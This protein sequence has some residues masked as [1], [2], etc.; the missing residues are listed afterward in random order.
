[1]RR[2]LFEISFLIFLMLPALA[3]L[4][5]PGFYQSQD[6]PSHLLRL[7]HFSQTF[8]DGQ[9]P[10]R[11]I[12][13]LAYGLGTPLFLFNFPLPYYIG[14]LLLFLGFS[15]V[16]SIEILFGA[17]MLLSG[18]FFYLW[19]RQRY[20][21][22]AAFTGALFYMWAPYRF[23]VMYHRAALGEAMA[24][25]FIPLLF[26]FIDNILEK[27]RRKPIIGL[28]VSYGLLITTHNVAALM[29]TGILLLYLLFQYSKTRAVRPLF[30]T[31]IGLF[32]GIGLAGFFWIPAVVEVGWTRLPGLA[33]TTFPQHF[34]PPFAL[35]RSAWEG[36]SI[37]NGKTLGMSFQLGLIHIL[38]FIGSAALVFVKRTSRSLLYPLF[39]IGLTILSVFLML[40]PSE[41]LYK[42]IPG[43]AYVLYPWR[44]L[45]IAVFAI[46]V[47]ATWLTSHIPKLITV[48]LIALLFIANRNHI[49]TRPYN[50]SDRELL[51]PNISAG[52]M[53]DEFLPPWADRQ[54]RITRA[55]E[56]GQPFPF[57]ETIEMTPD[58]QRLR[59]NQYYF[60]GWKVLID[61]KPADI[62]VNKENG[63]RMDVLVPPDVKV[64]DARFTD[65]PIRT[66]ANGLSIL[67]VLVVG[68][69]LV[70][71][72]P[73]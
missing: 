71:K 58:Q 1:M 10:V 53:D 28:A 22:F 60:P 38:I 72:Q 29:T 18:I 26:L 49:Q 32:L 37:I 33:A 43:L 11:W 62:I 68:F 3:G 12:S 56:V 7:A 36:G 63:G 4:F 45:G 39:W 40:S 25:L 69:L 23:L 65:T 35:I 44:F 66:L 17:S 8:F 52:D 46:A 31:I 51:S 61:G 19:M 48:G 55:R 16:A 30:M 15:V 2:R 20:P 21:F 34:V 13:T 5:P 24:F 27:P 54:I 47:L 41:F 14:S 70:K 73:S 57:I 6:G 67:S 42:H 50:V 9:F 64:I 59:V